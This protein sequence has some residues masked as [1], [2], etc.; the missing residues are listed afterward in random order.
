[1]LNPGGEQINNSETSTVCKERLISEDVKHIWGTTHGKECVRY[2]YSHVILKTLGKLLM[3]WCH[4]AK[5]AAH[6]NA[7]CSFFFLL[8][9]IQEE[10]KQLLTVYIL[11]W[12][13]RTDSYSCRWVWLWKEGEAVNLLHIIV[14]PRFNILLFFPKYETKNCLFLLHYWIKLEIYHPPRRWSD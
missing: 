13:H 8:F 12:H 10:N 14:P 5:Q 6:R 9:V 11:F 1:M 2:L 3:S 7:T 4:P